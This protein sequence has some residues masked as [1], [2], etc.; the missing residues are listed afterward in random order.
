MGVGYNFDLEK[1][2]G[3]GINCE[4]LPVQHFRDC[5]GRSL[6]LA[7]WIIGIVDCNH[8]VGFVYG[9]QLRFALAA[10]GFLIGHVYDLRTGS[11]GIEIA[12]AQLRRPLCRLLLM[13]ANRVQPSPLSL[14]I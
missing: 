5:Y 9:L 13:T 1:V 12:V 6:P 10:H 7:A 4:D 2:D 14:V 11:H 3:L 8:R